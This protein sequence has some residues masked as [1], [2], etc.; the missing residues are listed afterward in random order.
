MTALT[1]HHATATAPPRH[2]TATCTVTTPP[3]CIP[4]SHPDVQLLSEH[5]SL[6]KALHRCRLLF[7]ALPYLADTPRAAALDYSPH[8]V[9]HAQLMRG[10]EG[11]VGVAMCRKALRER[12][13]A[14]SSPSY[15]AMRQSR[16]STSSNSTPGVRQRW[17]SFQRLPPPSPLRC[18]TSRP[19]SS[20]SSSTSPSSSPSYASAVSSLFSINRGRAM[21]L[22]LES[23]TALLSSLPPSLYSAAGCPP[24]VHVAGTNGKGSVVHKLAAAL[25]AQGL[26]VGVFT[27]PHLSTFRERIAVDGQLISEEEVAR[28]VP[29]LLSSAASAGLQPTFFELCTA[30]ALVH[31]CLHAVDVAVVEV[32]LGGRLDSTNVISPRLSVITSIGLEH[33]EVLGPTVQAICREKCGI[34]KARTPVVVGPSVPLDVA[35]PITSALQ[36]ELIVVSASRTSS[37]D[38]E[39]TAIAA[40]ALAVLQADAA[41]LAAMRRR[42]LQWS[43]AAAER[44]VASRPACRYEQLQ[45]RSPHASSPASSI[46]AVLDVA[47]NPPAFVRLLAQL[48][49]DYPGRVVRCVFGMSADKDVN[50]CFALLLAH[51]RHVH[52]V[53]ARDTPR[54]ASIEQLLV[55]ER[56]VRDRMLKTDAPAASVTVDADGDVESSVA[57]ALR[58]CCKGD[59][60]LLVCGSFFIFREARRGL[61]LAF[62]TDPM[63]LNEAS[64]R[65]ATA[66][67]PS[68][69][70]PQPPAANGSNASSHPASASRSGAFSFAAAT[71]A[72]SA[73]TPSRTP[74]SAPALLPPQ[75]HHLSRTVDPRSHPRGRHSPLSCASASRHLSSVASSASSSSSPAPADAQSPSPPASTASSAAHRALVLRLYREML[76]LAEELRTP[77]T[78]T[79]R[80]D[81]QRAFRQWM[82]LHEGSAELEAAVQEAQSKAAYMRVNTPAWHHRK[83][84]PPPLS[85]HS[86]T[87]AQ[88]PSE[89]TL[90]TSLSSSHAAH[91]ASPTSI[92][93]APPTPA[94]MS[95]SEAAWQEGYERIFGEASRLAGSSEGGASEDAASSADGVRRFVYDE[96]GELVV[97]LSEEERGRQLDARGLKHRISDSQGITDEQRRRNQRL[98]DRFHFKGPYWKGRGPRS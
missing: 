65:P 11:G 6:L 38:E 97:S 74:I 82:Q 30:L 57:L 91:T 2:T 52:L 20:A 45:L 16:L 84:A 37:F 59:E 89:A 53:Q 83:P 80:Q 61:G 95:A 27:S 85:S 41:V 39:N 67:Q 43:A 44:A 87:A 28:V 14:S 76:H 5:A 77:L 26:R 33:M 32:G 50:G 18:Y 47:H 12:M 75:A 8:P 51:C 36:A 4:P 63:E 94:S 21:V 81:V 86:H 71:A 46:S 42:G 54:S 55:A 93:A 78:V 29:S 64:L 25:S 22:G 15:C 3:S 9:M 40:R 34:I 31:F 35:A 19:H 90:P 7:S 92:P 60:L 10:G 66:A 58:L 56:R 96:F 79:P 13:R 73:R 70:K 62:P 69:A 49:A 1:Q 17:A 23:M 68:E 88:Q 98:M 48:R 24:F 72:C